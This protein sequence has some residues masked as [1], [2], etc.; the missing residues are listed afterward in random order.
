MKFLSITELIVSSHI[1]VAVKPHV[2]VTEPCK[3]CH[4]HER[5]NLIDV[6]IFKESSEK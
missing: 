1:V 5:T 6:R 4:A 2:E 3:M